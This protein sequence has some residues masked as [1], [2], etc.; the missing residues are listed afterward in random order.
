MTT[1][2]RFSKMQGLGNDFVIVD[3]LTQTLPHP[4]PITAMSHRHTGIG[5]DQLLVIEASKQ[6]DFFCRI[7]N[8]DGSQA[9]QC[10]NGLRCVALYLIKNQ[11]HKSNTVFIETLAGVFPITIYDTANI[12]VQLSVPNIQEVHHTISLQHQNLSLVLVNVGNPHAILKVE[13]QDTAFQNIIEKVV[14]SD[15]AFKEGV[16]LGF[17]EILNPTRGRLRT[18]ERGAGRTLAC[19]SNACAAAVAGI[20][21]GWF[22]DHTV[23]IDFELGSLSITWHGEKIEM[24]G[25]AEFVFEGKW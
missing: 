23:Q 18:I 10:G 5:C 1:A 17:L 13:K 12:N 4:L 8:N 21:E 11:L 15:P 7:F 16:N 14:A 9:K 20:K 2:I 6:A 22:K 19:G 3:A 24:K 25:P